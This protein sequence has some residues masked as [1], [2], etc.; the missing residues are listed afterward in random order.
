MNYCGRLGS[1]SRHG[2]AATS[3]GLAVVLCAVA[4]ALAMPVVAAAANEW[5]GYGNGP[6][7]SRDDLGETT[8]TSS[9]LPGLARGWVFSDPSSAYEEYSASAVVE[10]VGY[11]G[12]RNG[13]V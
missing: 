10:G 7:N 3:V 5:N 13:V 6:A 4:T 9:T 1:L 12:P 11:F 2:V 8:L